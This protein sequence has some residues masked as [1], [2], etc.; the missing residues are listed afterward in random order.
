MF[1][2]GFAFN[3][4]FISVRHSNWPTSKKCAHTTSDYPFS[5]GSFVLDLEQTKLHTWKSYESHGEEH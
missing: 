5:P 2:V 3:N 1:K 4:F